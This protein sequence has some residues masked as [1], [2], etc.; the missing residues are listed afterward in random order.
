MDKILQSLLSTAWGK[1]FIMWVFS[2]FVLGISSLSWAVAHQAN[3]IKQLNEQLY[4]AQRQASDDRERLIRE[5]MQYIQE[6]D[7]RV[8]AIIKKV[9]R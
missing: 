8:N 2:L 6:T 3:E 5:T 7:N 4:L 1:N 9:K